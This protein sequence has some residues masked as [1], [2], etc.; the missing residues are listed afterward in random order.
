MPSSAAASAARGLWPR[1]AARHARA[2]RGSSGC[3]RAAGSCGRRIAGAVEHPLGGAQHAG[4][5]A[6]R[7]THRSGPTAATRRA[8]R[9][10][11]RRPPRSPRRRSPRSRACRPRP[12]A[13][14]R[15]SPTSSDRRR[16]ASG[17]ALAPCSVNCSAIQRWIAFVWTSQISTSPTPADRLRDRRVLLQLA[18]DERE[19]RP[20]RGRL[21][22]VG[23]R[24]RVRAPSSP[25]RCRPARAACPPPKRPSALQAATASS[26]VV[27]AAS[28]SSTASGSKRARSRADRPVD[29]RPVASRDQ[30]R[31]L[32]VVRHRSQA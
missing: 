6:L 30:V 8:A 26:P 29:L 27:S 2:G 17:S 20:G 1:G 16:H 5:V 12:R 22:V 11:D 19:R 13:R 14:T 3:R 32:Q 18:A 4:D 21:Q 15:S 10:A 25:R 23:D 9:R 24:L 7:P 28:C 31:R